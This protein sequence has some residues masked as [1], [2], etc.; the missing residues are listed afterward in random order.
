MTVKKKPKQEGVY[1]TDEIAAEICGEIA[2]SSRGIRSLCK[3]NKATWPSPKTI[4]QWLKDKED[5]RK[6]YWAAKEQQADFL[7][8]ELLEIADDESGDRIF[9]AAGDT[10]N[11]AKVQRDRLR[12]DT[13]KFIA[14]VL[15]PKRYGDPKTI[16]LL[17]LKE[18]MQTWMEV[19]KK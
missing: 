1:Y 18:E 9:S 2:T 3:D 11:T 8:D 6:K 12:I 10:A 17:E 7:V 4:F 13:R 14:K 5:F 16:E 19:N 15:L